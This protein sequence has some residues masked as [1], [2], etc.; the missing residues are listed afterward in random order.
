MTPINS[1]IESTLETLRVFSPENIGLFYS[2]AI[3]EAECLDV[4]KKIGCIGHL[5]GDFGTYGRE[6]WTTWFP[7]AEEYKTPDFVQEFDDLVNALR[8][9]FL[10]DFEAFKKFCRSHS[11]ADIGDD[12][13]YSYGFEL[14]S[15]KFFYCLRCLLRRGNYHFYIYCYDA[16]RLQKRENQKER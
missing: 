1:N 6:F 14:Q 10:K 8:K 15:D 3:N 13:M 9:D 5:R 12:P 11:D 16:V 4:D 2:Q 7:H